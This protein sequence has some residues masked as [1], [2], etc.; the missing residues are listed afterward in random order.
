MSIDMNTYRV[1][2]GVFAACAHAPNAMRYGVSN[3]ITRCVI[4]SSLMAK[5]S[6]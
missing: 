4:K 6:H 2:C 5:F 3:V 1:D